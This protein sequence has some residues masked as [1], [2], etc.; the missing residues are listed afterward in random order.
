MKRFDQRHRHAFYPAALGFAGAIAVL[1]AGGWHWGGILQAIGLGTAGIAASMHLAAAQNALIRS[2]ET[3]IAQQ[4][5]FGG[6]LV[7][8][9]S[10]HIAA[11]MHQMESAVADLA[12]RFSG[13]VDK[14]DQVARDSGTATESVEDQDGGLVAVFARSEKE[15]GA[16]VASLKAAMSS[17]AAMLNKIQDLDRFIAELQEMAADVASIAA[18]ANLL[19]LNAAIEAAHVGPAGRGFAVVANEFRNL[20]TLSGE[21][22]KRMAEKVGVISAAIVSTSQ[23]AQ[24]SKQHEDQSM[25]ASE[26]VIGSVLADFRSITDA[27]VRSSNLLKGESIDIKSEVGEALV[28]LQF[29]DRVS[30]IMAHVKCNIERLP[31]YLE[32][33]R[34]QFAQN[35]VLQPLDPAALLAE[36]EDTYAMADERAIHALFPN[37]SAATRRGEQREA[38]PDS[39]RNK[40]KKQDTQDTEITFF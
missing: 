26:F 11:S 32:Q 13:I 36:L 34:L 30:Q 24:D 40:V 19:A 1:L 18:Q 22:G 25:S 7:P 21:T 33:C 27:L 2:L 17:K 5:R 4:Q 35:G 39:H 28:Q 3:Y 12:E 16:V 23:A 38:L 10:G 20:S 6:K 15:L 31:D 9:W 29:Q 37:P 14:L 8:V